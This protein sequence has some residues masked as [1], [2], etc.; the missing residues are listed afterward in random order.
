MLTW[1]SMRFSFFQLIADDAQL[2]PGWK[3]EQ[4]QRRIEKLER[5]RRRGKGPPKK[6]A[7]YKGGGG[8]KK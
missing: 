6:G 5:L 4:E 1:F 7:K 2:I 3:N 8:K